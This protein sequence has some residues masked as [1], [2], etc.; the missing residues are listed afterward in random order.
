MVREVGDTIGLALMRT[1]ALWI[2]KAIFQTFQIRNFLPRPQGLRSLKH[3]HNV[4]RSSVCSGFTDSIF[5]NAILGS[6][7]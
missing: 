5:I 3:F 1:T 2:P 4:F 7:R 6:D